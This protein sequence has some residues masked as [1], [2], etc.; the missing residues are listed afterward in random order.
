M[1]TSAKRSFLFL[2]F[3]SAA[4]L[5]AGFSSQFSN[6]IKASAVPTP[7]PVSVGSDLG[8][9]KGITIGTPAAEVR[10]KL[11]D[12]ESK[13]DVED[14]FRFSDRESARIFYD[15]DKKVRVISVMY[16]GNLK[17][18]PAPKAA[19]GADISPNPDG[20]LHKTVHYPKDGFWISY[21]RTGGDDAM[22]FVTIQK[23]PKQN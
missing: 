7:T 11:G 22:V 1:F 20:A 15:A 13:S 23:M 18:A 8:T 12:P 16:S 4:A 17:S 10:E 21:A 3:L 14:D 6:E 9:Y 19:I 2:M 5:A